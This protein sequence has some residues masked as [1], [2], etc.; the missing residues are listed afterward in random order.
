MGRNIYKTSTY[1]RN[2]RLRVGQSSIMKNSDLSA[3]VV[4]TSS[5]F[6]DFAIKICTMWSVIDVAAGNP[7]KRPNQ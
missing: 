3:L 7:G 6:G 4:F 5:T 1:N 2:L